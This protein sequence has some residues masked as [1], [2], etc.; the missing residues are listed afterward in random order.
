MEAARYEAMHAWPTNPLA[1]SAPVSADRGRRESFTRASVEIETGGIR[2]DL[3]RARLKSLRPRIVPI[4]RETRR[5]IAAIRSR[6][7]RG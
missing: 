4:L 1:L 3:S 7:A 2:P 5:V 6:E